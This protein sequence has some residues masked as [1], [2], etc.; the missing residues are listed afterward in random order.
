[1]VMLLVLIASIIYSVIYYKDTRHITLHLFLDHI[2]QKK[3]I[4]KE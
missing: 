3:E 2:A 4:K 1:M